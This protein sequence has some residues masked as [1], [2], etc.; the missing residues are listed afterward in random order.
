MKFI[1]TIKICSALF[2]NCQ[3]PFQHPQEYNSWLECAN[4]GYLNAVEI[5][6]KL[7]SNFVNTNK[8]IINF[9]CK[10]INNIQKTKKSLRDADIKIAELAQSLKLLNYKI[11][12]IKNNDL[13]HLEQKVDLIYK[14]LFFLGAGIFTQLLIA[15]R[16]AMTG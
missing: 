11:Q 2:M 8:V 5:N 10:E 14:V 9:S 6:N 3:A 4:A 16:T 7:G 13:K 1:L 15:I 12:V